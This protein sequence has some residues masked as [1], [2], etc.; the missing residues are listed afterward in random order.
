MGAKFD[1]KSLG[2]PLEVDW[3]VVVKTPQDGGTF[4]EATFT[5]RFRILGKAEVE[6]MME[7][8]NGGLVKDPYAWI[9]AYWIGLGKD[10]SETL[11]AEM[12]EEMLSRNYIREGIIAAYQACARTAPTKN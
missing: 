1:F 4:E 5:G 9:N 3:P 6:A 10:E 7:E 12:R 2:Q 11:T 8:L